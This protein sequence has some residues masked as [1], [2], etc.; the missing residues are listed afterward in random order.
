MLYN[1]TYIM[2]EGVGNDL[3]QLSDMLG[4]EGTVKPEK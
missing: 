2:L 1:I 3:H 4:F